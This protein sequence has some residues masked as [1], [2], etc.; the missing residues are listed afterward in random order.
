MCLF[1]FIFFFSSHFPSSP[2]DT[3][4]NYSV[5]EETILSFYPSLAFNLPPATIFSLRLL[6]VSTFLLFFLTSFYFY[7]PSSTLSPFISVSLSSFSTHFDS[8][9]FPFHPI[10]TSSSSLFSL[11]LPFPL[12]FFLLPLL[13]LCFC[14]IL[15]C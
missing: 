14:F 9:S 5:N 13:L 2:G 1:V 15:S 11:I 6:P 7:P 10:F 8:L 4:L 3:E 12:F